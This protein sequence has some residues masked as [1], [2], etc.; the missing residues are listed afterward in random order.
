MSDS[1][2]ALSWDDLRIVKA[3]GESGSLVAAAA[4]LGLNHSTVS[5]RLAVVEQTLGAVLFDRRRSGYMTTDAG[6]DVIDL[7]TRVEKE[8]LSVVR[9]VSR[10]AQS[11]TG[12]L[13]ITTSDALL[14]DFLTP[15]IADFQSRN[16]G[17][18]IEMIVGNKPLNLARGESDIAF[19]ATLSAPENLFGRKLATI[20][21]AIYG[22]RIDYIGAAPTTDELYQRAWVSYGKGLSGLKA[23]SFVNDRVHRDNIVYRSDSVA[24]VASAISAG[25]GIGF[26]PCMHGDLVGSLIR[27]SAVEPEVYDELW[28]LTHPDIRKSGRVY[29]FLTHCAQALVPHRDFLEG[30][31]LRFGH[32]MGTD[33]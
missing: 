25:I 5:R 10:H 22:R 9:R 33:R 17:V 6:A 19:R 11:H 31:E 24:G 13:R 21:W 1:L 15:V 12:D 29:A 3:V 26:L 23:F 2:Q 27:I 7:A 8:I 14:L 4:A 30:R 28:V 20:A 18:R 32:P 16:P